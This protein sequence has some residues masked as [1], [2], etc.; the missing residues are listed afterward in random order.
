[1]DQKEEPSCSVVAR[2]GEWAGQNRAR[3]NK[4]KCE[5]L[6]LEWKNERVQY[7]AGFVWCTISLAE[8][9]RMNRSQQCPAVAT[10]VNQILDCICESTARRNRDRIIPLCSEFV[11]PHLECRVQLWSLQF[12]NYVDRLSRIQESHRVGQRAEEHVLWGK[13]SK[14]FVIFLPGEEKA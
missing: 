8:R 9:C 6:K 5:V 4:D 1:M 10:R 7:R 13:T 11:R 2:L 3:F 12:E 14:E